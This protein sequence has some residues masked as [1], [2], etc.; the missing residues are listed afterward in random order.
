MSTN[1]IC[2]ID[3]ETSGINVFRDE[4]MEIGAILVNDDFTIVSEFHSYIKPSKKYYI[5]KTAFDIHNISFTNLLNEPEQKEVLNTF[6]DSFGTDYRFGGW[7]ISFDVSFFRK[8]CSKNGMMVKY[9]KINHHHLDVQSINI[10]ANQL[11]LFPAELS[12]LSQIADHFNIKRKIK[13]SAIEDA[14][15]TMKVYKELLNLFEVKLKH[16]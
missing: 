1:R 14:I 11:K 5:R 15:I 6:F 9:N 4:P 13:H 8:M 7:N 10:L 12:S 2:F 16:L 3:F